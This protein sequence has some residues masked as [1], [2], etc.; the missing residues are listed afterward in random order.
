M[1][2]RLDTGGWLALILCI[3][4]SSSRMNQVLWNASF[5]L[6]ALRSALSV[7][8]QASLEICITHLSQQGLSPRKMYQAVPVATEDKGST[9]P[10]EA[11]ARTEQDMTRYR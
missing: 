8:A 9:L 11:C 1:D 4:R 6:P 5:V 7:R 10:S 3:P 2:P